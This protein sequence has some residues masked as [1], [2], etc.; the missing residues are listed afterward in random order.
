MR[1][2]FSEQRSAVK[3]RAELQRLLESLREGDTVVVYKLDRLARSVRDL[4]NIVDRIERAGATFKSLTESFDTTTPAGKMA[5]HML[6]AVAEFERSI[7]RERSMAGIEVAKANGVRLGRLPALSDRQAV[8]LAKQWETGAYTKAELGRHYGVSL[9][10]IKRTLWR[11]GRD[12]ISEKHANGM[13]PP[14]P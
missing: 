12:T 8:T 3:R 10:T 9:S 7:I 6:G 14:T 5:F 11:L 2:I 1:K 13:L 4:L